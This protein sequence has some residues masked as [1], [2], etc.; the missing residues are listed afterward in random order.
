MINKTKI[1]AEIGSNHN[2]NLK[3]CFQIINKAKELGFYAVKFQLFKI[4]KLYSKSKCN[5]I[6]P[7]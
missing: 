3:R 2:G 5:S 7:L 1:I 4:N 6:K